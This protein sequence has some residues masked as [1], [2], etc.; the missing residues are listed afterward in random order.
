MEGAKT[1]TPYDELNKELFA[2]LTRVFIGNRQKQTSWNPTRLAA[3][4]SK[5]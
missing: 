2:I 4:A 1:E 3:I 5:A